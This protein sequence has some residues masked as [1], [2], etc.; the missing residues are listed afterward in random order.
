MAQGSL[1]ELDTLLEIAKRLEYV[2]LNDWNNLDKEMQRIDKML[3]GLIHH[4]RR[5]LGEA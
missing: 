4:Q 2:R 3:T 1:S 5:K